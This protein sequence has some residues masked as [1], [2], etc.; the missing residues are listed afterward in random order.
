MVKYG[1]ELM[2]TGGMENTPEFTAKVQAGEEL[3]G[4]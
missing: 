3:C 2:L 4:A 1:M